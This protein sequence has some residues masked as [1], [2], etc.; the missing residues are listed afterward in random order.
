MNCLHHVMAY[1]CC[2][3]VNR[4]TEM[5]ACDSRCLPIPM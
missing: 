5:A 1:E 3:Y 2:K 4:A